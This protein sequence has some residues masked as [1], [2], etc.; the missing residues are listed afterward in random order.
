MQLMGSSAGTDMNCAVIDNS[1]GLIQQGQ[2]D[3]TTHKCLLRSS[4]TECGTGC[5]CLMASTMRV[6][7][8]DHRLNAAR[9]LHSEQAGYYTACRKGS[10][11]L[12]CLCLIIYT[13]RASRHNHEL[14]H[15]KMDM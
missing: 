5:L 7:I 1:K 14:M 3:C 9:T 12:S 2:L 11:D 6:S 15:Y 8:H 10:G 4:T 13:I